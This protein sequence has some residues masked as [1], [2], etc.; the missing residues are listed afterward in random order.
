MVSVAS[1]VLAA[2]IP[3]RRGSVVLDVAGLA[4]Q[5]VVAG[6]GL[7]RD[8]EVDDAR[9]ALLV[10]QHVVGLE[11]AVDEPGRV[12]GGEPAPGR[13][14]HVDDLAPGSRLGG[15]PALDRPARDELHRQEDLVLEH[16]DVVH[17]DDV[18]VLEPGDRLRLAQQARARRVL[19][20]LRR[21]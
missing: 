16:A 6:A 2:R 20:A 15:E 18:R 10:E 11:V 17:G 19:R 8:A 4:R 3:Q 13:D 9:P 5:L 12:R 14:E 1:G 21:A 7:A